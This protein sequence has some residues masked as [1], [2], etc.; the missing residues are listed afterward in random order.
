VNEAH[1]RIVV[2]GATGWYGRVLL[3]EYCVAYGEDSARTNLLLASSRECDVSIN[4]GGLKKSFRVHALKNLH[5]IDLSSYQTLFW[6]AFVLKNQIDHIGHTLWM[7][8]NEEIASQIFNLLRI[9]P[10]LRVIY[11]SSGAAL[12]WDEAP[13]YEQDPYASLKLKYEKLIREV[14]ECIVVYP[15]ATS[16]RYISNIE[17]FA[18]SS[19]IKQALVNGVINIKADVPVVRSYGSAHD[20]SRILLK[21]TEEVNWTV[22][23]KSIVPVTHTM[24]LQQ[25]AS[26]VGDALGLNIT[27]IR[28]NLVVDKKPSIYIA[29]SFEFPFLM[30]QWGLICTP[31]RDQI[32]SMALDIS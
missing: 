19:F 11:F 20:F 22:L 10:Q 24:E 16:G 8:R 7:Q 17:A 15:Y 32:R 28:P 4:I 6:Y 2:V 3:H 26:E 31:F 25:L 9:S 1:P 13:E 14:S 18:L 21:F 30:A 23:P 29:H 5:L 27:T 12:E